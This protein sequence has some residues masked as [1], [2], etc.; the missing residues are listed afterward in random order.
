MADHFEQAD[1]KLPDSRRKKYEFLATPLDN[2][3]VHKM[4]AEYEEISPGMWQKV[5]GSEKDM[6]LAE[7]DDIKRLKK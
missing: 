4:E 5:P 7:E 3:K 1:N 2:E 6:G